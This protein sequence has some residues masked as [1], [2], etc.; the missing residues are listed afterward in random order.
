MVPAVIRSALVLCVLPWIAGCALWQRPALEA[1]PYVY[2]LER[3]GV[4]RGT[5]DRIQAGRVLGYRDIVSLVEAGVP[6]SMIVPYLEAT[7]TPYDFS[8]RQIRRLVAAGADD[9]LVNFLG[10]AKG[11]YLE[12]AQNVPRRTAPAAGLHPYWGDPDYFGSAP[13]A[14]A[15]PD[16][17]FDSDYWR[18][19]ARTDR[20]T[21][22]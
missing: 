19:A 21:A 12:D 18:G 16:T 3:E 20:R 7:R 11:I 10:R 13:F 9:E 1:P 14:F 17:W 8:T 6:G 2:A 22:R 15:F 5:L 4:D